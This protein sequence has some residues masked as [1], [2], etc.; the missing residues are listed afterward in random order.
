MPAPPRA[1]LVVVGGGY[2][3][4][5]TAVLAKRRGPGQHV[6]LLAHE[7]AR[8]RHGAA[9]SAALPARARRGDRHHL[10]RRSLDRADHRQGHR[11][12]LLRALDAAG[13]GFDS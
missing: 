9:P 3:G 13:L 4:P 10:T 2:L 5:W 12:P 11:D 6:V 7:L 8:V 1:D